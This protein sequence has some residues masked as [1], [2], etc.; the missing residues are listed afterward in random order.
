MGKLLLTCGFLLGSAGLLMAATTQSLTVSATVD[1]SI[2]VTIEARSIDAKGNW[3][4]DP[5]AALNFGNLNSTPVEYQDQNGKT[6]HG[7]NYTSDHY[8]V[9]NAATTV[10]AG[11]TD[12]SLSYSEVKN[13]NAV[14]SSGRNGLGYKVVATLIKATGITEPF[15]TGHGIVN[16]KI[17]LSDLNNRSIDKGDLG[18]GTFRMYLGLVNNPGVDSPSTGEVFSGVD[19][20]GEY[21]GTL[22][23]TATQV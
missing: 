12:I 10:G 5:V 11:P 3:S 16:G 21:T 2:G 7:I 18:T 23:I 22:T 20:P 8:F 15:L 17:L 14:S 6:V 1:P 13:P 19:K 9:I 4:A